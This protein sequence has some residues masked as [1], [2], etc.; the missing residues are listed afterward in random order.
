MFGIT[1]AAVGLTLVASAESFNIFSALTSSP[2]TAENFGADEQKAK[3]TKEY[4]IIAVVANEGLG[5][6]ASIL[7]ETPAP[8]IGTTVVSGFMMWIYWRAI[9]RGKEANS[10]G[11]TDMPDQ[12]EAT[13][14]WENIVSLEFMDDRKMVA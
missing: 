7:G 9:E 12:P 14:L 4:V 13:N 10:F 5:L 11:W 6:G 8:F 1:P 3:S 2:W